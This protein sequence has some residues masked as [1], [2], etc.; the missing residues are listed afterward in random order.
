[1]SRAIY[2]EIVDTFA[3]AQGNPAEGSPELRM[4]VTFEEREG[5]T[6]LTQ[7]VQFA[8]VADLEAL[9]AMQMVQGATESQDRLETELANMT[10]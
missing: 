6:T 5:K 1:M 8:S 9:L 7:R 10:V 3:D 2:H 4:T